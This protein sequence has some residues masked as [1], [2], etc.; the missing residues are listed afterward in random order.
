MGGSGT[1]TG[2]VIGAI[3]LTGVFTLA[4]I[5]LPEVHPIFSGA[6]IIAAIMFL[7]NGLVRL[8]L[9]GGLR[10]KAGIAESS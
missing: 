5:W 6:L 8:N 2:P 10:R 1:I 3:F 4:K 7:P 9:K